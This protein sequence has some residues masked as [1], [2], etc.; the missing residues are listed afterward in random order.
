M[1]ESMVAK[2]CAQCEELYTD[3][4][5]ALQKEQLKPLWDRDWI[6]IVAAKQCAFRGLAQFYQSLVCKA[7]KAVGEEIARLTCA[8]EQLKRAHARL[9]AAAVLQEHAARAARNLAAAAKDNDFIYHERVPDVAQ[10]EPVARAPIAKPLPPQDKW[11][12]GR[13]QYPPCGR[14]AAPLTLLV[15]YDVCPQ[16]CSRRWCRWRCTRRCRRATRAA[17]SW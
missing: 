4:M 8:E 17:P 14:R 13:G 16:I 15:T 11:G 7:N 5:R 10:L 3:A 2:V 9:P 6:S 1:K 12:S